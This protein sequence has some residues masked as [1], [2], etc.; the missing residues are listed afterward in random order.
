MSILRVLAY[1][2]PVVIIVTRHRDESNASLKLDRAQGLGHLLRETAGRGLYPHCLR[3]P[4]VH[5]R[6]G[7]VSRVTLQSTL[8]TLPTLVR[9]Y[10]PLFA[11]P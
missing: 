3:S 4:I 11:I 2:S 5:D 9:F 7:R 10:R 6:V 1:P 8:S